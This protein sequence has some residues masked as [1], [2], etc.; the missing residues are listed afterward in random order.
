MSYD[1]S[2]NNYRLFAQLNQALQS[3]LSFM[4]LAGV[5]HEVASSVTH[6]LRLQVVSYF[7]QNCHLSQSS[8]SGWHK[9][10]PWSHED[11]VIWASQH[12]RFV[13]D[14]FKRAKAMNVSIDAAAELF[15]N[16]A[17]TFP[18]G[19]ER[20]FAIGSIILQRLL[21]YDIQAM[22]PR[23]TVLRF[24]QHQS[25]MAELEHMARCLL[26]LTTSYTDPVD[27][28]DN[29]L[30]VIGK[31]RGQ[32]LI[33]LSDEVPQLAYFLINGLQCLEGFD[34]LSAFAQ[35]LRPEI[36][37]AF[38]ADKILREELESR[39][40]DAKSRVLIDAVLGHRELENFVTT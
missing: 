14:G 7:L 28:N 40:Y 18:P 37:V 29:P 25:H 1:L 12:Q 22:R 19:Q 38:T 3:D 35:A 36:D 10:I 33:C 23:A 16:L 11:F 27:D 17:Q 4:E 21:P 24:S 8:G 15:W 32:A 31:L 9:R 30:L 20:H 34:D 39:L 5:F 13:I 6:D 26:S 2:L